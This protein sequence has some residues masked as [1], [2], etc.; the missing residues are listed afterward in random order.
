MR[1]QFNTG[2]GY[3]ASGQPITAVQNDDAVKFRDH[4]RG[5]T[6]TIFVAGSVRPTLASELQEFVMWNYDRNNYMDARWTE[7]ELDWRENCV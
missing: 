1:I 4:A 7:D 6:G 3:S 5:I 2:R